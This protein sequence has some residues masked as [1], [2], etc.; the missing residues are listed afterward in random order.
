MNSVLEKDLSLDEGVIPTKNRLG[1]KQ[2]L[3]DKPVKWG[4]KT[5]ML[6]ESKTG[7]V[8][9]LEVYTGKSTN[10]TDTS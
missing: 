6:C 10:D 9:N 5:Y 1:F 2:Y 3:K 4:I 8:Y 7:Y